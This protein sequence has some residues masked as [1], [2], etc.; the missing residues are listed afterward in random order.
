MPLTKLLLAVGFSGALLSCASK[1]AA[2]PPQP[3]PT[4]SA[5][6]SVVE[7]GT[8]YQAVLLTNGQVFFGKL[9]GLDTPYPVLREVFYVRT[10]ATTGTERKTTNALI[11]RGTEWHAPDVMILNRDHIVLVE[12]VTKDSQVAQ[13]IAQASRAT[14]TEK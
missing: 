6:A 4:A 13:L 1:P 12:P 7:L 3:Q 5:R 8:A 10:I 2:A 11:K 9:Q 14:S